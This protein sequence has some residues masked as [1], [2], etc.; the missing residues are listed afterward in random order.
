MQLANAVQYLHAIVYTFRSE[1]VPAWAGAPAPPGGRGWIQQL[2]ASQLGS[3]LC[4]S[5][6]RR[7]RPRGDPAA[8]GVAS[9]SHMVQKGREGGCLIS[10]AAMHVHVHV[11]LRRSIRSGGGERTC[12]APLVYCC[13]CRCCAA[14]SG[15][16]LLLERPVPGTAAQTLQRTWRCPLSLI[17][18][19]RCPFRRPRPTG[20]NGLTLW[21][22]PG[23]GDSQPQHNGRR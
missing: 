14:W 16:R 21:P 7:Q 5:R 13:R 18:S 2:G 9:G 17:G 10:R 4:R 23:T 6:L 19:G 1:H 8:W 20:I 11:P 15:R 12:I 3:T 22:G